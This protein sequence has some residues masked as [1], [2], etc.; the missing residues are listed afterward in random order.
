[1]DRPARYIAP[2]PAKKM[3]LYVSLLILFGG[4]VSGSTDTVKGGNPLG[5]PELSAAFGG[6]PLLYIFFSIFLIIW[7]IAGLLFIAWLLNRMKQD[8]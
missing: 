4:L 2:S 6:N 5:E 3:I 1:M 7:I 8:T